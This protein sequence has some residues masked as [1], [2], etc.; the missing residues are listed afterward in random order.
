MLCFQKYTTGYRG[1]LLSQLT[2][3]LFRA[4]S[5]MLEEVL[6]LLQ[7]YEGSKPLNL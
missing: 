6:P 4:D 1:F 7:R 2:T 3:A 5:V